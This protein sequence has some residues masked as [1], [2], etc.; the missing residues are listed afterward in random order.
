MPITKNQALR[1]R[2]IDSMINSRVTFPSKED[3]R[4]QCEETLYGS[5]NGDRI[6][7]SSI[8]KDLKFLK[9][10]YNAPIVFNKTQGGYEYT[11]PF[12]LD[13]IPFTDEEKEALMM[14]LSTLN[15]YSGI[16]IFKSFGE[17]I[18]RLKTKV[19]LNESENNLQHIRFEE[20]PE[21]SGIEFLE[22]FNTAIKNKTVLS[23]LYFSY[24]SKREKSYTVHPYCLKQYNRRWY[25]ICREPKN[26]RMVTLEFGRVRSIDTIESNFEVIN[27]DI[28]EYF[29]YSPGISVSSEKPHLVKLAVINT[30][31]IEI[32]NRFPLHP[33]QHF[34]SENEIEFESYLG[35][36]LVHN[37]RGY[38]KGLNIVAP[39]E[40]K[41]QVQE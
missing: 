7:I 29:K 12:S 16:G 4:S 8:E 9:D 27:F 31:L 10:E 6:S 3:L 34:T 38:G 30:A 11:S 35:A 23:I 22:V 26:D 25:A 24:N 19:N 36:E 15:R 1:L 14:A 37:I 39:A 33:L 21:Q 41:K 2:K 18:D 17:A 40:L 13:D 32:L 5:D 28:D 20:L